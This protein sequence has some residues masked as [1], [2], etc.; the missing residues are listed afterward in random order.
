MQ[1]VSMLQLHMVTASSESTQVTSF[2]D[3][4]VYWRVKIMPTTIKG[5]QQLTL[6]LSMKQSGPFLEELTAFRYM[7]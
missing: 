6:S 3:R 2:L 7:G 1:A 5:I 4:K